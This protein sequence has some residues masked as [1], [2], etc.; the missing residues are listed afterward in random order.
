MVEDL[1]KLWGNFSLSETET[2][3]VEFLE[4]EA[5]EIVERG[6]T[7]L[8]GKLLADRF[9]GKEVLRSKLIRGWKP[10]RRLSFKVLGKNL[11]LLDF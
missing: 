2:N 6:K 9:I 5:E 11:F 1:E 8:V 3:G 4:E 7:C 10:T